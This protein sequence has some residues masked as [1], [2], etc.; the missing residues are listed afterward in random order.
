LPPIGYFRVA[1]T[2][3][4]EIADIARQNKATLCNLLFRVASETMMTIAADPKHLGAHRHRQRAPPRTNQTFDP[5]MVPFNNV[6]QILNLPQSLR[7]M[8]KFCPGG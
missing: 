1:C 5:S 2:L 4:A 8:S 6:F 3:P 7:Q